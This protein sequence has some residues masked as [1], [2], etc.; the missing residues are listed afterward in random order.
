MCVRSCP[1]IATASPTH[2]RI[3]HS[4]G[5]RVDLTPSNSLGNL[6]KVE[7]LLSLG[8]CKSSIDGRLQVGQDGRLVLVGDEGVGHGGSGSGEGVVL[9]V[10]VIEAA[11]EQSDRGATNGICSDSL[12]IRSKKK[13][14]HVIS[15]DDGEYMKDG[16]AM[17][18]SVE[19]KYLLL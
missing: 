16:L 13:G 1:A 18:S 17:A 10:V 8:L 9:Y 15:E 5:G 11:W 4:H 7:T 6:L 12:K 3:C 2:P 19:M 14:S